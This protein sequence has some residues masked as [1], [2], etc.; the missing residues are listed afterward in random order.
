MIRKR[1]VEVVVSL[2]NPFDK[3][4]EKCYDYWSKYKGEILYENGKERIVKREITK[5]GSNPITH[6]HL[7]NWPDS[8]VVK[9]ETLA[10]L[11]QKV[12][13]ASKGKIFLAHCSAGLGRTGTFLAALDAFRKESRDIFAIATLIRHPKTGRVGSIQNKN[14]LKLIYETLDHLPQ[15]S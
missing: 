3:G 2:T 10:F 14:Q 4:K 8:G 6:F 13:E 11:V 1:N 15:F 9:P 7:E 5:K 12:H